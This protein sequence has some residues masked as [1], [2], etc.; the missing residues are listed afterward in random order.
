[1]V[2]SHPK[3]G[4][5]PP[6]DPKAPTHAGGVV[7]RRLSGGLQFLLV[8]PVQLATQDLAPE[9]GEWVLPKGHIERGE[10][11]EEAALREVLEEAGAV[12]G[13]EG[14]AGTL[15]YEAGGEQVRCVYYSMELRGQRESEERRG[16]RW[17]TLD[18]VRVSIPFPE[19]V[20]LVESVA[21][22]L[23]ADS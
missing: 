8:R 7:W 1:M 2:P 4:V 18:E 22:E 21:R 15:E 11:T 19:T 17:A 5:Q 3:R 9:E 14:L 13:L 10:S 20:A 6:D 23:D 12:A 16:V